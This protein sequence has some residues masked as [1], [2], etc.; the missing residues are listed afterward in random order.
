MNIDAILL[1]GGKGTRLRSALPDLPKPM[2]PIMD[3]PFLE[4]LILSLY[5]QG[6]SKIILSIGY[7]K[8]I[9]KRYFCDYNP[10]IKI[11]FSE[12]N[13]PLGTGGALLSALNYSNSENI[14][15]LNGDTF[16]NINLQKMYDFHLANHSYLTIATKKLNDKSRYLGLPVENERI[17]KKKTPNSSML[18]NGGIYIFSRSALNLFK[19]DKQFFSLEKEIF[20]YF[21]DRGHVQS[22]YEDREFIDIGVPIDYF[23]ADQF[24]NQIKE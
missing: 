24:F 11:L 2:A 22:Y 1:A 9:I 12:E 7:K 23:R 4:Y 20:T 17:L 21:F 16:F 15:V 18:F 5:N 13:T 6:I 8:E 3:K 19:S 10:G 14:M